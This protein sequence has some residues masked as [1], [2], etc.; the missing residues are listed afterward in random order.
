M[1]IGIAFLLSIIVTV[2]LVI[3]ALTFKDPL[4]PLIVAFLSFPVWIASFMFLTRSFSG[5]V[6]ILQLQNYAN[7]SRIR[8]NT[9]RIGR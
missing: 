6:D 8:Q 1:R 5:S 9:D 4:P 2:F 3:W 7:V